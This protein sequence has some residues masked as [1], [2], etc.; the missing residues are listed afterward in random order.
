MCI[1]YTLKKAACKMALAEWEKYWELIR[2]LLFRY[3]LWPALTCLLAC[4]VYTDVCVHELM[5]CLPLI[6]YF[7]DLPVWENT[8]APK[9]C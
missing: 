8:A 9:G 2:I 3:E 6:S 1:D 7:F 5:P 4:S